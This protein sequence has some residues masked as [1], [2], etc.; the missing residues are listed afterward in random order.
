MQYK[1]TLKST[2]FHVLYICDEF[3]FQYSASQIGCGQMVEEIS[4]E[5][6]CSPSREE[7]PYISQT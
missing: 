7:C 5:A 3:A 6:E 1:Y 2:D 4:L